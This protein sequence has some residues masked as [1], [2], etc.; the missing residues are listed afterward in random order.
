MAAA[1]PDDGPRSVLRVLQVL[2]ALAKAPQGMTLSE[3]CRA[4]S[5]PKTTLHTMLRMLGQGRYV[6]AGGGR[7]RVGP[8]AVALGASIAGAPRA[9]PDCALALLEDLGRRTGETALLAELTPDYRSCRYVATAESDAWLRFSV[10]VGSLKPAYATGSGQAM[11]AFLDDG[12][13]ASALEGMRLAPV[14]ARTV[15]TRG[16]LL[17]ALRRVRER[18]VS[19]VEGGTVAGVIS[20]AA[21]IFDGAGACI[22]AITVGGPTARIE[23]RLAEVEG[24]VAD[25]ARQASRLLGYL[26]DWPPARHRPAGGR[27]PS[28]TRAGA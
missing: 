6:T 9:F 18:G 16:A 17:R 28:K 20:V 4:L 23:P 21:P 10:P 3:L 19:S 13:L 7:F 5:L 27:R 12:T 14:T 11:L 26:G 24:E 22:G 2:G 8:E 1:T 25:A 15:V